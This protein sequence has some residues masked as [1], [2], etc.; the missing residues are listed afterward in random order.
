MKTSLSLLVIITS[1]CFFT[2]TLQANE[3]EICADQIGAAYGLCTSY[4]DAI[5]CQQEP[6]GQN[7]A[8]EKIARNFKQITG[9]DI[10][11]LL[12]SCPCFDAS[13]L[14][15]LVQECSMRMQEVLCADET[16]D[17]TIAAIACLTENGVIGYR[18]IAAG[19]V[20]GN[21]TFCSIFDTDGDPAE[22]IGDIT[23]AQ[24]FACQRLVRAESSESCVIGS[25]E[26]PM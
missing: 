6:E 20:N 26:M 25:P 21:P 9:F 22:L 4:F 24:L 16:S 11:Y 18:A 19:A 7:N 23:P 10:D 8:C 17:P 13:D 12:A 1:L 5:H 14:Y 2:P 15:Q 3:E